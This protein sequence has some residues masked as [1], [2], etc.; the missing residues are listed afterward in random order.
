[1]QKQLT[2]SHHKTPIL[3]GVS[4]TFGTAPKIR[5]RGATSIYGS[6]KPLWVVDGVITFPA[7]GQKKTFPRKGKSSFHKKRKQRTHGKTGCELLVQFGAHRAFLH[8]AVSFYKSG[9]FS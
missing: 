3:P 4:G 8:G 5:V 2:K 6:S 9:I 7:Y 1:M